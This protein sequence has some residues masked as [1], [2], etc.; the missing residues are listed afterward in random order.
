MQGDVI[1]IQPNDVVFNTTAALEDIYGHNTK[2]NK[3]A[4]YGLMVP[5]GY[6]ASIVTEL[7]FPPSPEL[8][9]ET[10]LGMLF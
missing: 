2:T 6:N 9:A 8:I 3:G 5:K 7:C 4:L 10:N 1:R